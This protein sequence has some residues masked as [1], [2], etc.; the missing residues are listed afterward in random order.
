MGDEGVNTEAA[1]AGD[2]NEDMGATEESSTSTTG[3]D[4][5]VKENNGLIVEEDEIAEGEEKNAEAAAEDEENKMLGSTG[6]TCVTGGTELATILSTVHKNRVEEAKAVLTKATRQF[7]TS[8]SMEEHER[9][10]TWFQKHSEGF[11]A[12]GNKLDQIS[13]VIA[14]LERKVKA[15][16][17][18]AAKRMVELRHGRGESLAMK[19]RRIELAA[20]VLSQKLDYLATTTMSDDEAKIS[21]DT[22]FDSILTIIYYN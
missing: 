1:A 4:G 9:N 16:Q 14:T 7:Q 12:A 2:E 20:S 11:K 17:A 6:A 18:A 22:I 3:E 21:F 15:V 13:D 8:Q 5:A 10:Y 19:E